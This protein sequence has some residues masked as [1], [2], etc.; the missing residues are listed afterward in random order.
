MKKPSFSYLRL[1]LFSCFIL[2]CSYAASGTHAAHGEAGN[3]EKYEHLPEFFAHFLELRDLLSEHALFTVGILLVAGYI[4]GKLVGKIKLPEIT[5]FIIAGLLL[6]DAFT[7]IVPHHMSESLKI[8]TDI[9]LGFIA[10]T[11]GGEFYWVKLKRMGKDVVIITLLQIVFTFVA[12]AALLYVFKL[13]LPFAL[14]LGA[15]AT[16]TAPAATVAIVQKLRA[17]GKF[18]DYLYGVVAL[19]DAG[20]VIVF[21]TVLAFASGM[22]TPDEA[23]TTGGSFQLVLHAFFEISFSIFQGAIAGVVLHAATRKVK[24]QNE[25]LIITLGLVFLSTATAIAFHLSPLLVNMASGAV[26]IN[27]SPANHRLFR[28]IEPLTPPI[29]ALFFV[30]AGTELKPEVFTQGPTLLLGTAYILA[31]AAGKYG[32]VWLGCKLSK[33]P[34]KLTRYLGLCMLPQAGVAL[35]LVLLIQSSPLMAALTDA[36]L[37]TVQDMVNIVLLSVFINELVGPPLSRFALIKGN[38]MEE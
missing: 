31:R 22:L 25:V 33:T 26:I 8:V 18:V 36:Q 7:G 11:I 15:I 29:Y 17:H 3:S 6:G 24:N 23:A 38:E 27:L 12:V 21:G 13:P 37:K 4:I 16:A 10:L 2:P 9:A 5:G 14:L 32:G 30:I 35:G 1:L 19:D 34:P 28:N 20:C